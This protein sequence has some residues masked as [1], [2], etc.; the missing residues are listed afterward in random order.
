MGEQTLSHQLS[1]LLRMHYVRQLKAPNALILDIRHIRIDLVDERMQS[2]LFVVV[3]LEHGI[4]SLVEFK[5]YGC[6]L[7]YGSDVE[8]NRTY[9]RSVNSRCSVLDLKLSSDTYRSNNDRMPVKLVACNLASA[10]FESYPVT[11]NQWPTSPLLGSRLR[12]RIS[13]R[14]STRSP[15]GGGAEGR[16]ERLLIV[17]CVWVEVHW[18]G[19]RALTS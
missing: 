9:S 5:H 6:I 18:G 4:G 1:S 13:K 7:D 10:T 2:L 16:R 8:R 17:V 3:D 14:L 12:A 11:G 15:S 19:C